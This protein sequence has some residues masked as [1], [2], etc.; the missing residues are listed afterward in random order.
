M[1]QLAFDASTGRQLEALC[2]IGDAVCRRE[3]AR[4][5]LAARRGERV[6]DVGCGPGFFCAELLEEVGE[7]GSIIGLDASRQMLG[8]A[9]RR[10]AGHENIAFR[11]ADATSLPVE[12]AGFD[13]ALCVQVLEYVSD[14]PKALAELHRVVRP[15]GRVLVWDT[16][17][18]T[19]SWHSGD[20]YRM[21]RFLAAWDEH[22]AHPSLPRTLAPAMRSAG[23]DRI[24]AIAH[25]FAATAWDLDTFGVSLIPLI[26]DFAPG[27][28]G[29]GEA[30]ASEWA[31]EQR[32]LGERGE[33]FFTYTQFCFTATRRA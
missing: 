23:L 18:A 17:W 4:V 24:H 28:N 19:V 11:E 33:F 15:G 7:D 27:R 2:Q 1:S 5:A 6:L 9:A 30:D 14:Y 3:I 32:K 20:P 10:C 16:D 25:T 21:Q 22:L 13:A 29:L 26:T 12:D 31:A 8:L